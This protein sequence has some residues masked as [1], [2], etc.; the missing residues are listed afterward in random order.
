MK[1][2]PWVACVALF[3]RRPWCAH[4]TVIHEANRIA[5]FSNE[6]CIGLNG[7]IP[8]GGKVDPSSIIGDNLV[9]KNAQKND[10]KNNTYDTINNNV[11]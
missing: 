2:N 9:W 10:T 11:K 8:V 5:V 3:S 7:W 4:V 6:T 1:N